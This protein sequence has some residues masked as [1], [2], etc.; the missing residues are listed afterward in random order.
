MCIA[1]LRSMTYAMKAK[2]A[3]DEIF[4]DSEIVKLEPYLTKKGCAY[5]VKFNCINLETV[6]NAFRNKSIRYT[7]I[8]RV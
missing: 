5:G 2:N 7:E 4:V 8:V 3:L 6:Q 1:A